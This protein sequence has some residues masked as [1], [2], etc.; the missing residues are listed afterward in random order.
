MTDD[1][2]KK[3]LEAID[4]MILG[5]NALLHVE[6]NK[7]KILMEDAE[8]IKGNIERLT[9]KTNTLIQERASLEPMSLDKALET[10]TE[11]GENFVGYKILTDRTFLGE[12][13]DTGF[14]L[15]YGSW[16]GSNQRALAIVIDSFFDNEKLD[17]LENII[18]DVLPFIRS[19]QLKE[20]SEVVI[21][22][23]KYSTND[24]K[25]FSITA[26]SID[27]RHSLCHLPDGSWAV[28]ENAA[29]SFNHDFT[30][31]KGGLR[32]CL[33]YV[34]EHLHVNEPPDEEVGFEYEP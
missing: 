13:K 30:A 11:H 34:K 7:L 20:G 10:Y 3:R 15:D 17:R 19:G 22:G 32:K 25:L 6:R 8:K 29:F 28:I 33:D 9:T 12:W 27:A 26:P 18:Y 24:I 1:K 2:T 16:V 4:N 14:G 5:N 31:T 21:G 23:E